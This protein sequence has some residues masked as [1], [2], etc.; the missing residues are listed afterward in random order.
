MSRTRSML[1]HLYHSCVA[2]SHLSLMCCIVSSITHMLHCLIYQSCVALSHLSLICCIVSSITH[3]LHCLIYHSYVA[4]SH[5]CRAI[6]RRKE[7]MTLGCN[8]SMKRGL[9]HHQ[10]EGHTFQVYPAHHDLVIM[11]LSMDE[12]RLQHRL[13]LLLFL[14][15][16][17]QM[18]LPPPSRFI[19]RV[20]LKAEHFEEAFVSRLQ[21]S[22]SFL[23]ILPLKRHFLNSF[24][25]THAKRSRIQM[26]T[27][28]LGRLGV[29]K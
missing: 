17:L 22:P 27:S 8:Q 1:R 10:E 20:L 28:N 2:L 13:S 25:V 15:R 21:S 18:S 14:S 6:S 9:Q 23:M 4:L 5:L 16:C 12:N 26:L 19:L 7:G 3:M 11:P 29:C 24:H